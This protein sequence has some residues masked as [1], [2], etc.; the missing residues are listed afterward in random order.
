MEE[1]IIIDVS[2]EEPEEAGANARGP[3]P[4]YDDP[5]EAEVLI[6]EAGEAEAATRARSPDNRAP[7][8]RSQSRE[9]RERSPINKS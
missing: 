1:P 7:R 8:L 9:P 4:E 2:M 3:S 6:E 5:V